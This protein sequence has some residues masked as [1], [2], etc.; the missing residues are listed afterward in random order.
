MPSDDRTAGAIGSILLSATAQS[1]AIDYRE[2]SAQFRE[3]A[4]T[5]A[6]DRLRN[7]LLYLAA[8]YDGLAREIDS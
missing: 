2:R 3:L 4:E 6:D 7:Q 5:E 8:Q 1:R